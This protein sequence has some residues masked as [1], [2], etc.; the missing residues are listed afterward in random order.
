MKAIKKL[1]AGPL[2]VKKISP[3]EEA[4]LDKGGLRMASVLYDF[5]VD[6]GAV[7]TLTFGRVLPAGA[8]V[9]KIIADELTNV[10]SGGSATVQLKAGS[11][12]LTGAIA[13]ADLAGLTAP[14]LAGSV[15]AIKLS[16]ASELSLAIA[17]A[18]LTA[19]KVRLCV[20]YMLP[21]DL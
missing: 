11:T 1:E 6:A 4:V 15:A 18:A 10:T 2:A 3:R 5:S 21:N 14:A 12:N 17:T 8:I 7:G 13:I 20:E 16:A 9:T 19:G